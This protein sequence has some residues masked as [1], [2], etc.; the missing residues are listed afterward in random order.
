M[1]FNYYTI[2]DKS[3][4]VKEASGTFVGLNLT[5]YNLATVDNLV[6]C[7]HVHHLGNVNN[8]ALKDN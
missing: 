5:L 1:V 2:K 6:V 8:D 4:V 7:M 3:Q